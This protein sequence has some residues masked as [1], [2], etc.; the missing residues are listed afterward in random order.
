M[1][2]QFPPSGLVQYSRKLMDYAQPSHCQILEFVRK[3][4][5]NFLSL[6]NLMMG[7][8]SVLLSLNGCR[9]EACW[10][11]LVSFMLDLADGAVARQLNACSALGIPFTYCGLPCPYASA[12]LACASLLT[13]ADLLLLRATA[14]VMIF[15]MVDHGFYPHDKILESQLWKKLVFAGGV[16]VMFL[17]FSPMVCLYHLMWSLSYILFPESLWNCKV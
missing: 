11:L 1:L 13:G 7:L 16:G 10:L 6:A 8:T 14:I 2:M 4:A 12:T 15:F 17:S 9:H 5:A 3:N